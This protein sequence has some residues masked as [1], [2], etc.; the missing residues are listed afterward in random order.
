MKVAKLGSSRSH[1]RG[2][3]QLEFRLSAGLKRSGTVNAKAMRAGSSAS[4]SSATYQ[5]TEPLRG[6]TLQR[7]NIGLI[8]SFTPVSGEQRSDH[9]RGWGVMLEDASGCTSTSWRT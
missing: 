3:R 8:R 7:L 2:E 5:R 9:T 4:S 1:A 6:L